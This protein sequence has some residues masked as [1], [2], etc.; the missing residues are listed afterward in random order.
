MCSPGLP[1]ILP[2]VCKGHL[3]GPGVCYPVGVNPPT[4]R[5]QEQVTEPPLERP[6]VAALAGGD[7][8]HLCGH[9]RAGGEAVGS[10]ECL[11]AYLVSVIRQLVTLALPRC[12]HL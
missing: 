3:A 2:S 5:L 7:C 12:S 11:G 9:K 4:P 1:P 6:C 8:S 10:A